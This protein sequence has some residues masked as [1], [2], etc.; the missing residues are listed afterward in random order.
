M[1]ET[2]V[3][4][5]EL[6]LIAMTRAALGIGIGML[7]SERIGGQARRGAGWALVVAGALSTIPL[8]VDVLR[9]SQSSETAGVNTNGR[10]GVRERPGAGMSPGMNPH[11][12]A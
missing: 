7:L 2:R 10:P 11:P 1:R 6:G 8:V 5:P 9:K 3:S 4:I 12:G